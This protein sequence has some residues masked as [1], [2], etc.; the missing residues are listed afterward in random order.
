MLFYEEMLHV[1]VNMIFEN[2]FR[3]FNVHFL[4]Q[5]ALTQWKYVICRYTTYN[6]SEI[7][8]TIHACCTYVE[9]I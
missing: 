2:M 5:G 7:S 8:N 1:N 4:N 3:V 9:K 6:V